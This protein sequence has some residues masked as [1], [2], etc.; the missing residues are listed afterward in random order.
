MNLI[1][2]S[3]NTNLFLESIN[4]GIM[5]NNNLFNGNVNNANFFNLSPI[6]AFT[7]NVHDKK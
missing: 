3:E 4:M 7:P 1:N 2:Q 6:S 5:K